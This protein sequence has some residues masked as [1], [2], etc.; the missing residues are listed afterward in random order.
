MNTR[1]RS[2]RDIKCLIANASRSTLK[3]RQIY[4][5]NITTPLD[6]PQIYCRDV[7]EVVKSL[8]GNPIFD[9]QMHF[10]AERIF[11]ESG[12]RLFN[13][14][15]TSDWWWE[16]QSKLPNGSTV[17]PIMLNSDATHL[18]KLGHQKVHPIYITIGNITKKIRRKSSQHAIKLLG[19]LLILLPSS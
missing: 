6:T 10:R 2:I 15:W 3:W 1:I 4:L 19:Y 17:I 13:E 16:I 12:K 7:V 8:F 18:D 5:N 14:I 11:D 9:G